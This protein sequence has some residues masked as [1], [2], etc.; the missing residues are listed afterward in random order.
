M[1]L[2]NQRQGCWNL[3]ANRT[4][5]FDGVSK[6]I[7]SAIQNETPAEWS[8]GVTECW[9]NGLNAQAP[10]LISYLNSGGS[11]HS[12]RTSADQC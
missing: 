9:N 7:Q 12:L 10:E 2:I 8:N 11:E 4:E 5:S 3:E 1:F 6:R